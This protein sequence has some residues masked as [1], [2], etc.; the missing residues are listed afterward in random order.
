[1]I[2]MSGKIKFLSVKMW[3]KVGLVL[4]VAFIIFLA[5][6]ETC[7]TSLE[8]CIKMGEIMSNQAEGP[9]GQQKHE[10]CMTLL[11]EMEERH[12]TESSVL[13]QQIAELKLELAKYGDGMQPLDEPLRLKSRILGETMDTKRLEEAQ[14]LQKT[15]IQQVAKIDMQKVYK[16]EYD[17]NPFSSMSSKYIYT[18][19]ESLRH[20]PALHPRSDQK[21]D[22]VEAVFFAVEVLNKRKSNSHKFAVEHFVDGIFRTDFLIGTYYNMVFGHPD[23]NYYYTVQLARPF[24]PLQKVKSQV[25][26]SSKITIN[27][28]MPLK[29]R[30]DKFRTFIKRFKS[31]AIDGPIEVFLTVV[32]FGTEGLSELQDILHSL[33]TQYAFRNFKVVSLNQEFSR[34]LGLQEGVASWDGSNAL[35]F[36]CDVDIAFTQKFLE[37][38]RYY[39]IPGQTVYYPVVF[40]LYNPEIVY[41]DQDPK[42]SEDD[43]LKIT[44]ETGF[45]RDFG[46]GMTCQYRTDFLNIGGFD[47]NIQGWGMEDVELYRRY[48]QSHL[49]VIR[50]PDSGIFHT[51]H[52]KDCPTTLAPE[53]YRMCIGSKALGEASHA[54]MGRLVFK[55][56]INMTLFNMGKTKLNAHIR[57]KQENGEEE[58]G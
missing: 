29:G 51:Y 21:D 36:F 34:G 8:G 26:D 22:L 27:F 49:K 42:P 57:K 3:G 20:K 32:Y 9:N 52:P 19:G 18:L 48:L 7:T 33:T 47:T 11:S 17:V 55:D 38:C 12:R 35:L 56:T 46:F 37:H 6:L 23:N 39:T 50:V 44:K 14:A 54:M 2:V 43:Q 24:A 41:H 10:D 40:S 16:D 15:I 58:D 4:L 53:Q 1:M 28:I 45:W 5:K 25:I 31:I 13:K 30:L